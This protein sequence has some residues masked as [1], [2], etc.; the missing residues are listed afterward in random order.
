[1]KLYEDYFSL[2]LCAGL[3]GDFE[4]SSMS[5]FDVGALEMRLW[6]LYL[7]TSILLCRMRGLLK[8]M[9]LIQVMQ[10]CKLCWADCAGLTAMTSLTWKR[11]CDSSSRALL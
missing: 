6:P 4:R 9:L 1:M 2:L 11:M 5:S 3:A 8:Q 7:D 10:G